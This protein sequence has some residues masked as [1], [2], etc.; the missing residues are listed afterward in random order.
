MQKFL[1]TAYLK[2]SYAKLMHNFAFFEREKPSELR[3]ITIYNAPITG[4][5]KIYRVLYSKQLKNAL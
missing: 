2:R 3:G 5:F 4:H 1:Y